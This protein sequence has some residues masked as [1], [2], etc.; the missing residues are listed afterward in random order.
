LKPNTPNTLLRTVYILYHSPY[1]VKQV[2]L[3][4]KGVQQKPRH[5][6]LSE[7][8]QGHNIIITLLEQYDELTNL[9]KELKEI[10]ELQKSFL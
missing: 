6:W 9:I 10:N 1:F 2:R 4:T 3:T 7:K 5:S 8:G